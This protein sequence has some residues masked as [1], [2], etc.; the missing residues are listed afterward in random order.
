MRANNTF[1]HIIHTVFDL[2]DIDPLVRTM[3]LGR[4]DILDS[5]NM[6]DK[7]IHELHHYEV[8]KDIPSW[9][10]AQIKLF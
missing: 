7:D 9:K 4:Y 6:S 1:I 2:T 8:N 5:I 3:K 10:R